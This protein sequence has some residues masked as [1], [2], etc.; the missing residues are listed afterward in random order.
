M[1]ANSNINQLYISYWPVFIAPIA[2][3]EYLDRF[4]RDAIAGNFVI[5]HEGF[6]LF[7]QFGSLFDGR[8]D[9]Q[10]LQK[11]TTNREDIALCRNLAN[12]VV[13]Q[14]IIA[15]QKILALLSEYAKPS[16]LIGPAKDFLLARKTRYSQTP[17]GGTSSCERLDLEFE[18][19]E[20]NAD[21]VSEKSFILAGNWKMSDVYEYYNEMFLQQKKKT[22][23]EYAFY[24]SGATI[25]HLLDQLQPSGE[26]RQR[27]SVNPELRLDV[28]LTE[29]LLP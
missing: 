17:K 11:G 4:S 24:F 28:L 7:V 8:P 27:V 20:G 16:F 6:H 9:W 13:Q 2:S 3:K 23:S 5:L 10:L 19:L 18:R 14:E 29:L 25:S 1:A 21:Y 22:T 12:P 26:W 15:L